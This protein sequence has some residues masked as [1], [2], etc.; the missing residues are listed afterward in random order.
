MPQGQS[1]LLK[2]SPF[3]RRSHFNSLVQCLLSSDIQSNLQ[4]AVFDLL[5]GSTKEDD[6]EQAESS[7]PWRRLEHHARILKSHEERLESNITK[8]EIIREMLEQTKGQ[9]SLV[10]LIIFV[11][12][13]RN[14]HLE[15]RKFEL[16]QNA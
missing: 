10:K 7:D 13:L 11:F 1:S 4:V 12:L 16:E 9:Y 6:D 15:A 5:V 2:T 14:F 8:I 3:D